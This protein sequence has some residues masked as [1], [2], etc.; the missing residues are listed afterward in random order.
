LA[1]FSRVSQ[2]SDLVLA[3]GSH[4][5]IVSGVRDPGV[6]NELS[7]KVPGVRVVDPV[8]QISDMLREY[9][10][11]ALWLTGLIAVLL[12]PVL[13]WRY[14]LAGGLMVMMPPLLAVVCGPAFAGL[15]G[16]PF[17]VFS[18]LALILVLSIGLDYTIFLRESATD[19]RN[20]TL[21]AVCLAGLTTILSFGL[22]VFSSLPPVKGFG[23]VMLGGTIVAIALSPFAARKKV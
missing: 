19:H 16:I 14:G 9:R 8:G 3:A 18:A 20:V 5:V 6:V 13:M 2:I 4:L 15:L 10:L 23:A 1:D 7:G 11:R 22:L 12:I 21:L 17:T